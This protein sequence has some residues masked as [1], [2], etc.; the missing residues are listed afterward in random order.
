MNYT[1]TITDLQTIDREETPGY[2]VFAKV[3]ID[4]EEDGYNAFYESFVHFEMKDDQ[5]FSPYETLTSDQVIDWI[6][7]TLGEP[8]IKIA[9]RNLTNKINQ[10]RNPPIQPV[11]KPLPWE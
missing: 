5:D 4:V 11:S 7:S 3:R 6:K 8:W 1:W 10:Q 9:Y 2:V